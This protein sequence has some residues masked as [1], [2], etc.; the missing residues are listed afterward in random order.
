MKVLV[1]QSWLTLCDPLDCS[2]PGSSVHGI[3]QDRIL[4]WAAISFS[5]KSS[6]IRDQSWVSC[7]AGGFFA[8]WAIREALWI[9]K[10]TSNSIWLKWNLLKSHQHLSSSQRSLAQ[11]LV[12][13]STPEISIFFSP[14]PRTS[15]SPSFCWLCFLNIYQ[16]CQISSISTAITSSYYHLLPGP[17]LSANGYPLSFLQPSSLFFIQHSERAL[18]IQTGITPP[19]SGFKTNLGEQSSLLWL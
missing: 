19:L 7:I 16:I 6:W 10:L 14:S 12:H 4:E 15:P 9:P 18:K 1:T 13:P 2:L 8:I 17:L 5:R 3:L 11:C